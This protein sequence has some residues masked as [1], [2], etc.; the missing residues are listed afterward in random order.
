METV[1][2]RS[3]KPVQKHKQL[4]RKA[5]LAAR[6]PAYGEQADMENRY[7]CFSGFDIMVA[8]EIHV[9]PKENIRS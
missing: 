6:L 5:R 2:G 3:G 4:G 9:T 7:K 1:R 8:R